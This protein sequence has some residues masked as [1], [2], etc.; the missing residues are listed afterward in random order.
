M[1]II[2]Q[3]PEALGTNIWTYPNGTV[4]EYNVEGTRGVNMDMIKALKKD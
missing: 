3:L 4:L 1:S 2:L